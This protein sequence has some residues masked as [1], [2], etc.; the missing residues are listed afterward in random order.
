MLLSK[1]NSK[2]KL[3][4]SNNKVKRIELAF[5]KSPK[6]IIIKYRKN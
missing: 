1:R 2:L 4:S 3:N 6:F 5:S